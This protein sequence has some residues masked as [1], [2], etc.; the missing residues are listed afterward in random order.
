MAERA[1]A[2]TNSGTIRNSNGS[3][4]SGVPRNLSKSSIESMRDA[5]CRRRNR[6]MEFRLGPGLGPFEA[7][8]CGGGARGLQWMYYWR[9]TRTSVA[10]MRVPA[11][12]VPRN[13]PETFDSPPVRQR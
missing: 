11:T 8:Y 9:A 3:R 5:T 4:A 7:L 10:M 13:V 12:N 1:L 2:F 6:Q